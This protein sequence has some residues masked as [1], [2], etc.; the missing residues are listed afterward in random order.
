MITRQGPK[1]TC[2]MK[3]CCPFKTQ[4]PCCLLQVACH[5]CFSLQG[6]AGVVGGELTCSQLPRILPPPFPQILRISQSQWVVRICQVPIRQPLPAP[7]LCLTWSVPAILASS[8]PLQHIRHSP[9][10][11]P[12][13]W[14]LPLPEML[15]PRCLPL[16]LPSNPSLNVTFSVNSSR[17]PLFYITNP[18]FPDLLLPPFWLNFS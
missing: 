10:S 11:G 1:Q 9:A 13:H 3:S 14:Q 7:N 2:F 4:C 17:A 12:L 5:N 18:S 8:W 16:L 6:N 15:F